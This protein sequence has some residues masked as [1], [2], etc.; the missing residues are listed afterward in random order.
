MELSTAKAPSAA[1]TSEIVSRPYICLNCYYVCIFCS[2]L[3]DHFIG[4]EGGVMGNLV[5]AQ[6]FPDGEQHRSSLGPRSQFSYLWWKEISF[7]KPSS[8]TEVAFG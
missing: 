2:L 6:S 4:Q 7:P 3:S 1:D 5:L 8:V